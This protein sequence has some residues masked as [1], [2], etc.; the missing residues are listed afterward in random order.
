MFE[1]NCFVLSGFLVSGLLFSEYKT[2]RRMSI[3]RFYLRRGWKIYPPFWALITVSIVIFH[4]TDQRY[5]LRSLISE[6]LF[7]QSYVP[8]LWVHTWSLAVEEHFYLVLPLVL[9]VALKMSERSSMPF[10]SVVILAAGAGAV[11]LALR[12]SHWI[13]QPAYSLMTCHFATHLRIDSLFFGVAIS[14]LY[15]FHTRAFIMALQPWRR[16]LILGGALLLLPAFVLPQQSPLIFT[17]GFTAFYLGSGLM[18][19]GVLLCQQPRGR[20]ATG[21]AALGAHSYSIYLWNLP[22]RYWGTPLVERTLGAPMG[23]GIRAAVYVVGS[24]AFGFA[25]AKLIES[26]AL[27]I[28]D[29]WFPSRSH[30]PLAGR[31]GNTHV[32][33]VPAF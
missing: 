23:F 6:L 19:S 13:D 26:P 28:R 32:D 9:V 17:A 16:V 3:G 5:A 2:H 18:I 21:L 15:H 29:R 27:A 14:Y 10:K 31:P 24:L 22:V 33:G 8:S 20:L 11:P 25:M 30:G 7:L 12:V 1:A 4:F